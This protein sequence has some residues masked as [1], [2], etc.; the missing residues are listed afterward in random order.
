MRRACFKILPAWPPT[1]REYVDRAYPRHLGETDGAKDASEI[2][3]GK[4]AL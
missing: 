3:A 2:N 4:L 1:L